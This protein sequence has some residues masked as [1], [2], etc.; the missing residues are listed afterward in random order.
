MLIAI[1]A[2]AVGFLA[3]APGPRQLSVAGKLVTD[4]TRSPLAGAEVSLRGTA[5]RVAS[6]SGGRF[7]IGDVTPGQHVLEVRTPWLAILDRAVTVKLSVVDAPLLVTVNVPGVRS[8][9]EQVCGPDR[10]PALAGVT[11]LRPSGPDDAGVVR[12][13]WG[14]PSKRQRR[15]IPIGPQGQFVLCGLGDVELIALTP[16]HSAS[17]ILVQ[18]DREQAMTLVDLQIP[19]SA[20]GGVLEGRIISGAT[21]EPLPDVEIAFPMLELRT[22]S[23]SAGRYRIE[24]IPPGRNVVQA[25]RI[26]SRPNLATVQVDPGETVERDFVLESVPLLE[27]VSVTASSALRDFDSHRQLGLGKFVTRAE[28]AQQEGRRLS[29]ILSSLGGLTVVPGA[30][31]NR[32]WLASGRQQLG[33]C[34]ELEGASPMDAA[35]ACKCFAQVFLDGMALYAGAGRGIVPD[36]NSIPPAS[37]EAIEFYG[38][39]ASL[40]LRYSHLNSECG[41]LVIHTRRTP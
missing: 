24:G 1:S 21:R 9:L 25:R 41:V 35:K 29:D 4:S 2:V 40:P 5:V 14:P 27:T 31:G 28:L 19:M 23:D 37:I 20:T 13:E 11:S 36:L 30:I 7:H 17:A 10:I 26:G 39:P 33:R 34:A 8:V 32:A 22:Y 15:D 6:D 38:G 12:A 3:A 18:L 16:S